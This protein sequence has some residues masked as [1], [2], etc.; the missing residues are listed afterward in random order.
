MHMRIIDAHMHLGEDLMFLSDDS[1]TALLEAMDGNG[2][3]AQIL[4]PGIVSN[5]QK[6]A[7]ERIR[8]FADAHPGRA[9]G[10][11]C[12]NPLMDDKE[13]ISLVRW[14][15]KDLGFK[16]VKLHP[17]AFCMSPSHP[18]A[19]KIFRTAKELDIVVMIHTGNGLPNALPSLCIPV[20]QKYSD[21][22]IVLAH[23]GGGTFGADAIVAAQQCPNIYLET[24]WTTVYDLRAM[25]ET[26]GPRRVMFGSDIPLN[27][28]VELAKYRAIGL[29][30]SEMEWCLAKTAETVF[31]L[32]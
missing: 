32:T 5:D 21:L 20:A 6:K 8:K 2:I 23:A 24:S 27:I 19:D 1:E 17:N 9:F 29:S 22:R 26:L 13:Y 18:A 15:A 14:T 31:K 10:L 30:E 4:Q 7:H 28:P 3:N 11:A 12:F 25:V 16:G